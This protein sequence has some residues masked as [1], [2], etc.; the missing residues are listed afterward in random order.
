MFLNITYTC[1]SQTF[2][3]QLHIFSSLLGV[4]IF[5]VTVGSTGSL[6]EIRSMASIDSNVYSV[7]SRQEADSTADEW[8]QKVC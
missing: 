5:V 3:F 2:C 4:E 8:L 7:L 1:I 6:N